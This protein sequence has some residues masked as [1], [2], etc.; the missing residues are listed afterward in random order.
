MIFD[1]RL[2]QTHDTSKWIF[3]DLSKG[4]KFKCIK[5]KMA[6]TRMELVDIDYKNRTVKLSYGWTD[7]GQ[8]IVYYDEATFNDR[9][10]FV[11]WHN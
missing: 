4:D 11:A 9:F 10:N 7:F 1:M 5:G 6:G 3:E 2:A 8:S